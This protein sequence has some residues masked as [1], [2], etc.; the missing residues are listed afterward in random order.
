M[1][2]FNGN[3]IVAIKMKTHLVGLEIILHIRS[4]VLS[5]CSEVEVKVNHAADI[6]LSSCTEISAA[7][8]RYTWPV[9]GRSSFDYSNQNTT[10]V[11]VKTSLVVVG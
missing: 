9:S 10:G 2:P 7:E 1:I 5:H 11:V 4:E 8:Q 6:G 3:G